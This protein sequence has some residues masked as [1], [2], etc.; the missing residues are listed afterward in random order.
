[1]KQPNFTIG[2]I[3]VSIC[4]AITG[5]MIFFCGMKTIQAVNK[6]DDIPGSYYLHAGCILIDQKDSSYYEWTGAEFITIFPH[7]SEIPQHSNK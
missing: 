6:K 7:H 5:A 2:L 4:S 3:I 1:M